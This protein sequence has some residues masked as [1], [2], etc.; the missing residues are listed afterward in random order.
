MSEKI[1]KGYLQKVFRFHNSASIEIERMHTGKYGA[2]GLKRQ[3]KRKATPE[4]IERQNRTNRENKIRRIIKENFNAKKDYWITLTYEAGY[5]TSI[6]GV[7][8]DFEKFRD[9]IKYQYKKRGYGCKWV[10]RF[11]VGTLGAGHIHMV[12]NRIPDA[13]L[14]LN[15]AWEQITGTG[16]I[17]FVILRQKGDFAALAYYIVKEEGEAHTAYTRSRN[18][19][20]PEPRKRPIKTKLLLDDPVPYKGY[21]IDKG[22]IKVGIN[23]VTGYRYQHFTMLP[24]PERRKKGG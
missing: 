17:D 10:A 20:V 14:I 18:L 6:E 15:E 22:S 3:K 11:G 16:Y 9:K 7:R 1:L 8:E 23:P 19:R 2:P 13:D 12:I 4:E 21:Y 5:R 24:L